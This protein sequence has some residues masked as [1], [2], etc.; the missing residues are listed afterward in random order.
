MFFCFFATPR[1]TK[2]HS[3]DKKTKWAV[4]AAIALLVVGMIVYPKMK[5]SAGTIDK[6]AQGP[7]KSSSA[8]KALNV[9]AEVLDYC[10]LTDK[11]IRTG[12]TMPDEEVDLSFESSGK[13][14]DIYFQEGSHVKA[15]ELLAKINDAPLQAQLKKLQAQVQ[16]ATDRVYR[17]R[18]L[19]EKDAVSQE[20]FE[21]VQTEYEQL[22]A[23]IELVKANIAQTELRAPF[24]GV[25][26]LRMVSEG[27]YATPS[28]V[29]AKLTKVAP[30]KIE[31][32]IPESYATQVRKG[33]K[34]VFSMEQDGLMKDYNAS[35]FAVESVVDAETRSLKVR[36]LY[37]NTDERIVP[38][39]FVSVE[40]VREEISNAIA[41]PSEAVVPEMGRQIVYLYR[42]G[43]AQPQEIVLG[44]RTEDKVQAVQGLEKGDTLLTTG[45]MQLRTG[46][47][48]RIENLKTG[49]N[50]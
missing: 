10:T 50:H 24:D 20:A 19:L 36:A 37:P 21:Q 17:Q 14:V 7:A 46:M 16:L 29:I 34:I 13:I 30:I 15:G 6:T 45:V 48:V 4:L 25:I 12:S 22:M 26:G 47:N 42:N 11:I 28:T 44:L 40:V 49:G 1:F 2:T 33:S 43:K 35:V 41:V 3:Y 39:R 27:A 31:F 8:A 18:T 9:E 32:S 5:R 38:G 23:D